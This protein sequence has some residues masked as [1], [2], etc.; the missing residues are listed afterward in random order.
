MSDHPEIA[1]PFV[2]AWLVSAESPVAV[3]ADE[4]AGI[5]GLIDGRTDSPLCFC[6]SRTFHSCDQAG[7]PIAIGGEW[8]KVGLHR[9]FFE[10][11]GLFSCDGCSRL[12]DGESRQVVDAS[13]IAV[14][15]EKV[16]AEDESA[17]GKRRGVIGSA[18]ARLVSR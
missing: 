7:E 12:V 11:P 3:G 15:R 9:Q 5:I 1:D 10:W 13:A 14:E 18:I 6:G 17:E 2:R 8:R 16:V 4:A